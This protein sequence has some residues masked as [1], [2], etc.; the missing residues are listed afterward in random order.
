MDESKTYTMT[1]GTGTA[2]PVTTDGCGNWISGNIQESMLTEKNLAHVVITAED[3]RI[4]LRDQICD[5][6]FSY[7]GSKGFFLRS[8]T[9]EEKVRALIE[10]NAEAITELA[11]LLGGE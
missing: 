5:G 1:F 6:I 10:L 4:E 9:E 11:E 2:I 3:E 8:M 7:R